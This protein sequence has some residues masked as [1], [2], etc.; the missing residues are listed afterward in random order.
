M[1]QRT[2]WRYLSHWLALAIFVGCAIASF[3]LTTQTNLQWSDPQAWMQQ[4]NDLGWI[5]VVGFIGILATAIVIG[6]LPSTPFTIASGAIWGAN[7][8]AIYGTIGIFLGS[9]IAYFIGRTLGRSAVKALTGKAIQFS[10]HRGDR[11]LGWVILVTH[12]IPVMPYEFVSYGA[13]I[14]GL[15]LS[16]FARSAVLGI[17]P[18]TWMLTHLGAALTLNLWLAVAIALGFISVVGTLAWGVRRHN[19][20]G[21]NDVIS[22]H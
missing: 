18:C 9:V 5:G 10:S 21:L 19:W 13:G 22:F 17:A 14:S 4:L 15:S 2:R 12:L 7:V 8:A 1:K 16:L 3:V 11:Y 20:F 6:P